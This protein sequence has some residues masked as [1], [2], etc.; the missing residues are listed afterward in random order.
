MICSCCGKDK[1]KSEFYNKG[2]QCKECTKNKRKKRY[3]RKKESEL[4]EKVHVIDFSNNDNDND[5][6]NEDSKNEIFDGI[7]NEMMVGMLD[8]TLN[9]IFKL[10]SKRLGKHWILED[11]ES[12]SISKPTINILSKSSFYSKI[13]ENADVVALTGA[14]SFVLLPRILHNVSN[15]KNVKEYDDDGQIKEKHDD[16]IR[17]KKTEN[18]TNNNENDITNEYSENLF[19][20]YNP[21]NF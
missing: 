2:K 11:G 10:L 17:N 16:N 3:E 4:S 18:K 6:I 13:M 5:T 21:V 12:T 19:D 9:Q 1:E 14:L 15:N 7:G 8:E 20:D